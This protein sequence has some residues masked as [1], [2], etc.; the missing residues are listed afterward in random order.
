M[1]TTET[2]P[3]NLEAN[4]YEA[5][6]TRSSAGGRAR[7]ARK[8]SS[9]IEFPGV[10]RSVVPEW[11][12]EVSE[13]VREVQERRAREAASEAAAAVNEQTEEEKATPQLELLPQADVPPINPLVAAALKRIERARV[14]TTP[15]PSYSNSSRMVALAYATGNRAPLGYAETHEAPEITRLEL[16]DDNSDDP[17]ALVEPQENI[18]EEE[19]IQAEKTHNLVVVPAP[20]PAL[21]VEAAIPEASVDPQVVRAKP[22]KIIGDDLNNSALNYLDSIETKI[23]VEDTTNRASVFRRLL[24]G[25]ID[26]LMIGLLAL[27]FAAGV[28]LMKPN[29]NDPKVIALAAAT[30]LVLN[31]LYS[32]I[33]TALTGRTLG[34]KLWSLRVV[35]A[36]TGLIPTGKQSAGRALLFIV[37]LLSAGLALAYALVD[38]EKRTAHD[39]FTQTAVIRA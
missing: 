10:A 6:E 33:C 3:L 16:L 27:P 8:N 15:A 19:S 5:G 14:E 12:K 38:R 34:M 20:V 9:V 4:A 39:R 36:R 30:L 22:R 35:D 21:V 25:L 31:F 29:W 32:T 28:E 26:L 18:T 11:R 23:H 1:T 24:A 17:V 13:R 7:Q 37:S 2:E